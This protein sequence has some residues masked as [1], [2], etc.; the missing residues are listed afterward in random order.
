MKNYI[1]PIRIALATTVL[2]CLISGSAAAQQHVFP[3]KGQ[4]PEQQKRDEFECHQWAAQQSG[5]D[6]TKASPAAGAATAP[7]PAPA[8]EQAAP[9]HGRNALRGAARGYVFG[10]VVDGDSNKAAWAGAISGV[11]RGAR[12]NRA[13]AQQQAQQQQQQAQQQQAQQQQAQANLQQSY[14]RARATCLDA[15]GY[16][17]G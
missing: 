14:A 7:A 5:Y 8:P 1:Q 10:K 2:A 13:A 6:P 16:S 9:R 12:Q 4:T 3:K 11:A 17:V 15:K